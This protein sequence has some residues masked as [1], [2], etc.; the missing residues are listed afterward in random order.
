M[1]SISIF[2]HIQ[3]S[4]LFL[5]V[6]SA[7]LLVM[8]ISRLKGG[9]KVFLKKLVVS[10]LLQKMR[11]TNSAQ[12]VPAIQCTCTLLSCPLIEFMCKVR[13]CSLHDP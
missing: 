9:K 5:Q 6:R 12:K 1:H 4:W 7:F 13:E 3:F 8:F 2:I 11:K 10:T